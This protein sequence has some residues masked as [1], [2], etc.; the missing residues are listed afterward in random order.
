MLSGQP[1]TA[2]EVRQ[3]KSAARISR[4]PWSL[5]FPCRHFPRS[6]GVIWSRLVFYDARHPAVAP[7]AGLGS[8]AV[9]SG[10]RQVDV[11]E[12]RVVDR[13]CIPA[14]TGC[15]LSAP[16]RWSVV[17]F[18]RGLEV[19][20][21]SCPEAGAD[22]LVTPSRQ[23]HAPSGAHDAGGRGRQG[24]WRF[25]THFAKGGRISRRRSKE[26]RA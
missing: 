7:R 8:L 24:S 21:C 11:C 19:W 20:N 6:G 18:W 12:A 13:G 4:Q 22:R 25:R 26:I 1:A 17:P 10:V 9:R 5:W 14:G 15:R 2:R 16:G 3:G 23:P